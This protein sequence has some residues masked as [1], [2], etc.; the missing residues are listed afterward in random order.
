MSRRWLVIV[1]LASACGRSDFAAVTC[2]DDFVEGL[3][4]PADNETDTDTQ[5]D[6][7][8][9]VQPCG[10]LLGDNPVF[11][12]TF[13]AAV[14][15]GTRAGQLDGN[16]WN[17]S[18]Q[19]P[20]NLGQGVY[21]LW[22]PTTL[23]TCTGPTPTKVLPPNDV[24]ICN[25]QLR[26]AS[27]DGGLVTT[28]AMVPKQAF[29]F[30]GRTGTISFDV[31]NDTAGNHAA[32]P[33][34]WV[35][36]ELLSSAFTHPEGWNALPEHGFLVRFG[37][38]AVPGDPGTCQNSDN[39]DQPRWTID[40]AAV[41][42][43]YVLDDTYATGGSLQIQLAR[44]NCVVAATGPG[45]MN[46]VEVRVSQTRIEV[47]ASDAGVTPTRSNMK[48]IAEITDANLLFTRGYIALEDAHFDGDGGPA[49]RPSQREHTFAWDNVA[50]DGPF[51]PRDFGYAA[52]NNN[53]AA[54]GGAVSLAKLAA[55][56][57]TTSWTVNNLPANRQATSP[58]VLFDFWEEGSVVP[59]ELNVIVNGNAHTIPWP[60][61]DA[62]TFT[63]RTLSVPI[64][65]AD[66][67]TGTNTVE[68]GADAQQVYSNVEIVLA[69][70]PDS[71]PVL[72]G[73]ST[74]YPN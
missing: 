68:I 33:E 10:M 55:S 41:V 67:V 13:D 9:V 47:W 1:A 17:V 20:V 16:V 4:A 38:A 15:G 56:G 34:L 14:G 35:T 19:G 32:W 64:A 62:E 46:H 50:F 71:V 12:D 61:P 2:P 66:L 11:C 65:L 21:N 23:E 39:V 30:A 40:T 42:R 25:G 52:A 28:L 51:S 27:N 6:T 49:T 24:V 60:Y 3:C 22:R 26:E 63:W 36:N 58:R 18:H 43:N 44:R 37:G 73:N 31:S 69:D 72:P 54:T 57:A 8:T 48:L 29:D 70:V 59:T 45:Q 74:A 7:D 5:T 53:A